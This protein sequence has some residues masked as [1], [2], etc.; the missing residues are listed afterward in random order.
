MITLQD[1]QNV[2]TRF[3]GNADFHV[4]RANGGFASPCGYQLT[5]FTENG[6]NQTFFHESNN[7]QSLVSKMIPFAEIVESNA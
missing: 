3:L 5:V 1:V 2:A 7:E 4:R 6:S